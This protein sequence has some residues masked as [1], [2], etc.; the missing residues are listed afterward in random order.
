MHIN[1]SA[2]FLFKAFYWL[3][4]QTMRLLSATL[5]IFFCQ[6][7][8]VI[9]SLVRGFQGFHHFK[10]RRLRKSKLQ[11]QIQSQVDTRLFSSNSEL[12]GNFEELKLKLY[13]T[14]ARN[15]RDF[16]PILPRKVK[17]YSC[18]PT[19]YDYAHGILAMITCF[20]NYIKNNR[21]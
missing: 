21:I 1:M 2:Y 19:V 18:G 11:I 9:F 16:K 7:L 10:G 14:M 5:Q 13:D 6:S 12:S 20:H 3:H 15:K 4:P 17:F 8:C